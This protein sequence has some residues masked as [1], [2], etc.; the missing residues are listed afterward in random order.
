MAEPDE[1]RLHRAR[2]DRVQR[3]RLEETV[4]L[5]DRLAPRGVAHRFAR[6]AAADRVDGVTRDL[7]GRPPGGLERDRA[8][9]LRDSWLQTAHG[10]VAA[11]AGDP[12]DE[13]REVPE[14]R[15]EHDD[16]RQLE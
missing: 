14:P 11:A 13:L 3:Q 10:R 16:A 6:E 1:A 5:L 9:R 7:E 4:D 15:V 8:A 2:V 12:N